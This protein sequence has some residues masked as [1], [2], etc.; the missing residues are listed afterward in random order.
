VAVTSIRASLTVPVSADDRFA[1]QIC[2]SRT[3]S[4]VI[5]ICL[6]SAA[7]ALFHL[8]MLQ[9][10]AFTGVL[11]GLV[12]TDEAP[13]AG[14]DQAV[15]TEK[16]PADTADCRPFQAARGIGRRSGQ[17]GNKQWYC[18]DHPAFH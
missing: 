14:P 3:L 10:G 4:A 2:V 9:P 15:V 13:D 6:V 11:G 1:D 8:L 17:A 12:M 16:M 5:G 18:E 7:A